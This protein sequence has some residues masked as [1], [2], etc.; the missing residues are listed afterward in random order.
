MSD[1]HTLLRLTNCIESIGDI[2]EA[3]VAPWH[4]IDDVRAALAAV[5]PDLVWQM[6]WEFGLAL[7]SRAWGALRYCLSLRIRVPEMPS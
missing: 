3:S 2:D 4:R 7:L 1:T 6:A 5:I